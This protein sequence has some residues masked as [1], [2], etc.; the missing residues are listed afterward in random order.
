M[1]QAAAEEAWRKARRGIDREF[2]MAI[3]WVTE[4]VENARACRLRQP[5]RALEAY[6]VGIH[7]LM[8]IDQ[9]TIGLGAMETF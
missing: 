7:D 8:A 3:G 6:K 1:V 9:Y 2:G 4:G 5:Q